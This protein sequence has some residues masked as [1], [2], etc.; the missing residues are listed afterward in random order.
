MRIHT[1]LLDIKDQ[2]LIFLAEG[3]AIISHAFNDP[4][5]QSNT[6]LANSWS[7]DFVSFLRIT[8]PT[9]KEVDSFY[10]QRWEHSRKADHREQ[11]VLRVS[12]ICR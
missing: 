11:P 12:P 2:L 10:G 3:F 6:V 7:N 1:P 8:F 5:N 4:E 9:Q